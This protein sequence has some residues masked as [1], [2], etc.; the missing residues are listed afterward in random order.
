MLLGQVHRAHGTNDLA[1]KFYKDAELTATTASNLEYCVQVEANIYQQL[2]QVDVGQ[3]HKAISCLELFGTDNLSVQ[4][5]GLLYYALG[6][7]YRS[8]GAFQKSE[9]LLAKSVAIARELNQ[10]AAVV[11]RNAEL[12]RVY[13]ATGEYLQALHMQEEFYHFSLRWGDVFN[14]ANACALMGFT[15]QYCKIDK[16]EAVDFTRAIQ[17][18]AVG[19]QLSFEVG[20]L[21]KVGWC[22]NNI[23]KGY[24]KIKHFELAL[25]LCEQ[26]IAIAED[27]GNPVGKGTA[28]GNAGLACR[29][30]GHYEKALEYHKSYLEIVSKPLDKAWMEHEV[31]IDYLA[32]SDLS[33]ALHYALK[34][35]VTSTKIRKLYSTAADK[36]KVANFDKNQARCFNLLQ[37]V[38]VNQGAYDAALVVADMGRARAVADLVNERVPH[39]TCDQFYTTADLLLPSGELDY[40]SVKHKVINFSATLE[41]LDAS[42][43]LYSIIDHPLPQH[44]GSSTFLYT[45]VLNCHSQQPFTFQ[46]ILPAASAVSAKLL[47]GKE[48]E[49]F[50]QL[51]QQ[52]SRTSA[53]AS[54]DIIMA[55]GTS[56]SSS[57]LV[58][59]VQKELKHLYNILIQPIETH[60]QDRVVFVPHRHLLTVPFA[61]LVRNDGHHLAEHTISSTSLNIQL[62]QLTVMRMNS[63]SVD[64]SGVG[65]LSVGNPTM[66]HAD[67][68]QLIG[69]AEEAQLVA[70][71][72]SSEESVVLLA[73][74]ANKD[75]VFG[76][77]Q[78]CKLAHL[79]THAIDCDSLDVLLN[80]K[81]TEANSPYSEYS[82]RGAIILAKSGPGCSG[83]LTC[84]EVQ[85]MNIKA[86]LVVLS[87]CKTAQGKITNDSSLGL[88]RAFLSSGAK[89]VIVTLWAID[90]KA[91]VSFMKHFY[92][93]Y[94]LGSDAALAL[95]HSMTKMLDDEVYR[96]PGYWGAFCLIGL[97]PGQ[98]KKNN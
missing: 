59:D 1:L 89:A 23:A 40:T 47:Y 38:L 17:Y 76:E 10:E 3:S 22:L 13:R 48:K 56:S 32:L 26:R 49:Y 63:G 92:E 95:Q 74:E 85:S 30:L 53:E 31:A 60:L 66:P 33:S 93:H 51:I 20:A 94:R 6:C 67:I 81:T 82:T 44:A 42:L 9:E 12:S 5:K 37:Y 2:C 71:V 75:A 61:A 96:S 28:F 34:E 8:N 50:S 91:T 58:S 41:R 87:C 69:A 65:V 77:L 27:M 45:W 29:G 83:L 88:S 35:L 46:Q 16:C 80:G 43:V 36:Q 79:A 90:D 14:L 62:L 18:L 78:S 97:S 84:S 11:E 7:A 70:D 21:E 55:G 24:V 64:D 54:R 15:L 68:P 39:L 25:K 4:T 19:L 98:I 52:S 73:D 86:D 72:L 57:S